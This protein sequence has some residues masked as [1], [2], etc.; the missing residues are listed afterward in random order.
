KLGK[1]ELCD[2][3]T[4]LLDEVAEMPANLQPK[5]LQVLQDKQFFRLGG[6]STIDVDVRILAATNVNV[7]Q[8]IVERKFREDLYYRLS[9]FTITMPPLRER[10]DETPMLLHHFMKR[11][12]EQYS[13][14]AVPFTRD[15][16]EAC[17]H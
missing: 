13:R 7:Q 5:L 12:A 16:I 11:M 3:G 15:L 17:L 9:A 4:I 10:Q 6:E 2:K 14:P 1:F 8:A